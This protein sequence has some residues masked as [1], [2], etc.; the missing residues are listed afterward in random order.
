MCETDNA[1]MKSYYQHLTP[2]NKTD[3]SLERR[4][5]VINSDN[6]MCIRYKTLIGLNYAEILY[7]STLADS[8]R[9]IITRW[10]LSCHK[11]RIETGRYTKPE[12]P[13]VDRKCIVCLEIEEE[14]HALFT[15]KAHM[16]IRRRFN[17]LLSKNDSV[18]KLLNPPTILAAENVAK[19]LK[20]IQDNMIALK[21]IQ[22]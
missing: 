5:R 4:D 13:R 17:E 2:N 12:T 15:C 6:T 18:M 7:N 20:E 10:R 19:Y 9:S 11:L 8:Y 22:Y 1:S 21:M 14:F 3:N 16:F